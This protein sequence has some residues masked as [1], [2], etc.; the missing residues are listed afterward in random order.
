MVFFYSACLDISI[1]GKIYLSRSIMTQVSYY[2]LEGLNKKCV[3]V[4]KKI[5]KRWMLSTTYYSNKNAFL[6]NGTN[7]QDFQNVFWYIPTI[8]KAL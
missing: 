6:C 1:M 4:R 2:V 3:R 8:F 7:V 5:D